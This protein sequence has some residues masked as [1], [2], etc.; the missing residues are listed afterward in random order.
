MSFV[1]DNIFNCFFLSSF[2]FKLQLCGPFGILVSAFN[3]RM[4]AEYSHRQVVKL[5][6][7]RADGEKI[8]PLGNKKK[9]SF[10]QPR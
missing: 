1:R 10:G 8:S 9:Q 2:P 7:L 3:E 5:L 4:N 6:Q